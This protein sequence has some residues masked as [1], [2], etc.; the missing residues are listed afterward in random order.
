MAGIEHYK[1]VHEIFYFYYK[2]HNVYDWID[3]ALNRLTALAIK[4]YMK[5]DSLD[6][7]AERKQ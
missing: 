1:Y 6:G 3:K 5:L 4:P 2:D 7:V